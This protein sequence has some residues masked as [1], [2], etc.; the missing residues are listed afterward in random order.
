MWIFTAAS[1]RRIPYP[2][3]LILSLLLEST[4]LSCPRAENR[5]G[6]NLEVTCLCLPTICT[7]CQPPGAPRTSPCLPSPGTSATLPGQAAFPFSS[8]INNLPAAGDKSLCRQRK[9]AGNAAAGLIT[10]CRDHEAEEKQI[11]SL[12]H[13]KWPKHKMRRRCDDLI[14]AIQQEN[15]DQQPDLKETCS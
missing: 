2:S 6:G 9:R 14:G 8:F 12:V 1:P 3:V 15:K 5:L 7:L 10:S 11:M 13:S 4:L